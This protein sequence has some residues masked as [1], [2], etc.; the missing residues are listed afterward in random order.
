MDKVTSPVK[1]DRIKEIARK[2]I[3]FGSNNI[4]GDK[5]AFEE[6]IEMDLEKIN[7]H[8]SMIEFVCVCSENN[9]FAIKQLR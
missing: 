3:L 7:L 8:L 1:V 9:Y 2:M 4:E 5:A 6:N